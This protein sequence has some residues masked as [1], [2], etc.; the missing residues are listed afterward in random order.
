MKSNETNL[1]YCK[2]NKGNLM[3]PK[4]VEGLPIYQETYYKRSLNGG[5]SP[6]KCIT[7]HLTL[8]EMQI[9]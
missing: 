4:E 6:K 1:D 8:Q 2:W 9:F 7:I 3:F 5:N